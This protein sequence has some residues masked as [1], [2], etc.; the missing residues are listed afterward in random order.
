[1]KSI[2]NTLNIEI[3]NTELI[4]VQSSISRGMTKFTISGNIDK[5]IREARNRIKSAFR[6][7]SL[8]FPMGN[9]TI[10]L[11]PANIKKSGTSF[12]LPIAISILSNHYDFSDIDK[13][14]ICGEIT[15]TGDL[16]SIKNPIRIVNESRKLGF[17]SVIIPKSDF[18]FSYLFDDIKICEANNL[19]EVINHLRGFKT[20][21]L[22]DDSIKEDERQTEFDIND[23]IAQEGL[24]RAL[25]IAISGK[26]NI[27]I[28]GPV[29]IGKT[30]SIKSIQSIFPKLSHNKSIILSDILSRTRDENLL[31]EYPLLVYSNNNINN[32]DLF[33]TNKNLGLITES[34][35]G[36]MVFDEINTY[37]KSVLSNIKR[38]L[39]NDDIYKFD[40]EKFIDYPV[41]FSVI[42]TMNS[43]PCGKLGTNEKCNC[44]MSEIERYNKK[45]DNA[46]LDRF[47]IKILVDSPDKFYTAN[48]TYDIDKIKNDIERVNDVQLKRY[49]DEFLNNGYLNSKEIIEF[50]DLDENIIQLLES[51]SNKYKFS[52]RRMDNLLK[53]A[54]TIADLDSKSKIEENHIYESLKYQDF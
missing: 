27:L 8:K 11:S 23:I 22:N 13:Y 35:F 45:I 5:E 38:I 29:G 14:I 37:S 16:V 18:K 51:I 17:N 39:D 31:V 7:N 1:M 12:D 21:E 40:K 6:Y 50:F 30:V 34:N 44:T 20:I 4:Q 41:D 42:A 47:H 32:R 15:L 48:K 26:H 19:K 53:V 9:L 46:L 28:K 2:V 54:R 52:K 3:K 10:N 24:I 49:S 43:C 36:Y 25:I 33:G